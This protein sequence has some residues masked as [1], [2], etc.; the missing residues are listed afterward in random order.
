MRVAH[1]LLF[2]LQLAT[3]F[4]FSSEHCKKQKMHFQKK[5]EKTVEVIAAMRGICLH[6]GYP[7]LSQTPRHMTAFYRKN[8]VKMANNMSARAAAAPS[9]QHHHHHNHTF[10]LCCCCRNFNCASIVLHPRTLL[11]LLLHRSSPRALFK[12]GVRCRRA[13]HVAGDRDARWWW[14]W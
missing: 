14:W 8:T 9:R 4:E 3:R 6:S 2:C 7:G 11:S 13:T 10:V 12:S 1:S 5:K